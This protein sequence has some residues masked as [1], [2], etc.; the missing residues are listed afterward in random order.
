[1]DAA[2]EH[3][4]IFTVL[5]IQKGYQEETTLL[6]CIEYSFWAQCCVRGSEGEHKRGAP[7]Y[8]STLSVIVHRLVTKSKRRVRVLLYIDDDGL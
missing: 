2:L 4:P 7:L 5:R 3:S 8:V 1:M 6:G